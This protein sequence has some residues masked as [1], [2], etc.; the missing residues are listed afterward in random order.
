VTTLLISTCFVVG[1]S[2]LIEWWFVKPTVPFLK[3]TVAPFLLH[4]MTLALTILLIFAVFRRPVFSSAIGFVLYGLVLL[5]N[6]AKFHALK[7]PMVFSDFAMFAQ[8]LK[9]PRLYLPYLGWIPIFTIP[10]LVCVL[11][12]S[13]LMLETPVYSSVLSYQSGILIIACLSLLP[14]IKYFVNTDT[15]SL[16]PVVDVRQ[17]GLLPSLVIGQVQ[18]WQCS[19]AKVLEQRFSEPVF[20]NVGWK[21]GQPDILV[22]QS[23]SF[24]DVRRLYPA[25]SSTVLQHFDAIR[26]ESHYM[27]T[28]D[29]DAWGA[30]TM[31][32][33]FSFLTGIPNSRLG[34]F[35]FYP[36]HYVQTPVNSIAWYFREQGYRTICIHP[37]SASFFER[38]RVFPLLGFDEF[39]D[40]QSFSLDDNV[41]PY[42]GDAAITKKILDI[43]EESHVPVFV[44]SITMENHGPLHLEE[45]T[46]QDERAF[47]HNHTKPSFESRDLSIYLRHLRN[48]DVMVHTLM[49]R[50]QNISRD[51][52]VCFYG[53][54]VPSLPIVYHALQF[55]NHQTDYFIWYNRQSTQ[56]VCKPLTIDELPS[57]LVRSL[58]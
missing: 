17:K 30:N 34:H 6:N 28:L 53:D 20:G 31:R 18:A 2:F 45:I 35:R 38:D 8:S 58:F 52:V 40:I 55:E 15:L 21:N 14:A 33:E 36:Y 12:Y 32:T 5:I 56:P 11:L 27:G 46:E 47:Y 54:H 51:S 37:H 25:I 9:H 4:G 23:E 39:L 16:D 41:G 57:L 1:V 43:Q 22:I 7:E 29:V 48:A 24:F 19:R 3:G 26:R 13:G 49:H 50:L 44:F 42:T 10:L